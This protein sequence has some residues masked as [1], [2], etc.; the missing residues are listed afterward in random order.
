M[1]ARAM[2]NLRFIRET[3]ERAGAF[4]AVPGLGSI[5]MGATALFAALIAAEQSGRDAWLAIWLLEAGVAFGAGFWGMVLKARAARMP[6]LSAAGRKFCLSLAPPLLVCALLTG[7]LYLHGASDLIPGVWLLL[8][9]TGVVTAGAFSV[10]VVPVMGL[11][12][13]AAGA[14]ALLSPPGWANWYMAAGFG[15]LHV[16]FGIVIARRYGG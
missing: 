5:A 16:A 7:V 2:D 3:M 12:F 8:Y 14:A 11:C 6:L 13:M 10:R 15:G 1:H 9:G 4:T